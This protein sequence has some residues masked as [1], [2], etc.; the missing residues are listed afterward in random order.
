MQDRDDE[1]LTYTVEEGLRILR[2]GKNAGY[3]EIK[4]T[5]ALAGVKVLRIGRQFRLPG[6]AFRK[7]IRGDD[8]A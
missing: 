1:P 5:G 3:D 7:A 4:R 2:I 6:V 8:A